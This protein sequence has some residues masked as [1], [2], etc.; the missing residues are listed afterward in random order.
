[1]IR[2]SPH[3]RSPQI[4]A[5][6]LHA[7]LHNAGEQGPFLFVGSSRGGLNVLHYAD[8]YY[9]AQQ[10]ATASSP[11]EKEIAGMILLDVFPPEVQLPPELQKLERSGS[12][13]PRYF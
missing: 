13:P 5:E 11:Q 6:E 1:M 12:P 4:A 3:H 2:S 7:L 10:L 8:A 9:Q